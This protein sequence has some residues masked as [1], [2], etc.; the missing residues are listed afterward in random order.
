MGEQ[1]E[2]MGSDHAVMARSTVAQRIR[3]RSWGI[4]KNLWS[5]ADQGVISGGTFLTSLVLARYLRPSEFGVYALLIGLMLFLNTIQAAL[6]LYPLSVA[7]AKADSEL[8]RQLASSSLVFTALGWLPL[9]LGLMGASFLIGRPGTAPAAILALICSQL[10]LTV[11]GAFASQLRLREVLLGDSVSYLGQVGVV[12][13]LVRGGVSSVGPVFV[14]M[15]ATSVVAGMI[16]GAQLG[17]TASSWAATRTLIGDY[18]RLGRWSV[19]SSLVG[20]VTVQA[21]PWALA[22]LHGP[23]EAASLLVVA[24]IL[25]ATHPIMFSVSNLVVPAVALARLRAGVGAARRTAFLYGVQGGALVL[26]YYLGLL[27]APGLALVVFYGSDS[28]YHGLEAEL[29]LFTLSYLFAYAR[30]P[31]ES[32][33]KGLEHSQSAMLVHVVN[34]A[35]VAA[36][37]LPLAITRGVLG[38]TAG[39]ALA[40]LGALVACLWLARRI[41]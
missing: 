31:V 2:P 39:I 10:H 32:L 28:P 26:P 12:L 8:L 25:G 13:V 19:L 20:I 21:P 16:Q 1:F 4:D 30:I 7:G 11:R 17:L 18:W 41:A 37:V 36:F 40:G 33:L 22:L 38:A 24:N 5:L 6:V 14:A 23:Q 34:A 9:G 15:A 3:G 35:G 27:A 29:R